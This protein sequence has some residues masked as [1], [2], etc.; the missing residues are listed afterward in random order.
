MACVSA[1]AQWWDFTDPVALPGTVNS[2]NA[3]ESMPVFSADSATLYFVR[4][5]DTEN[6]G[7]VNDQDIWQSSRQEDG[8]YSDLK[9]IKSLNNKF[10]NGVVGSSRDG[11]TLYLLH[12]YDGKKDEEKGIAQSVKKNGNWSTPE[13]ITIPGLDIN[14]AYY[15]FH[16]SPKGDIIIISYDGPNSLGEEDLYVSEKVGG[17]WSAP[18]HMGAVIN[19][20]GF[21]ISPYLSPTQDTLF[22]STNGM[23]GEGDADIFY[24][25]K[26]G[27][28]TK[29]SSPKNL[30]NRINS[31]KFDA[32]FSY[33]GK[34]AYWSSNRD[35]ELGDIYKIEILTPPPLEISCIGT[36]VSV[37]GGSDGMVDL[38]INGGGAPY[39]FRWSNGDRT[40]DVTGLTAGDYTVT[41]T[42]VI[43]Q[44]ATTTCSLDEPEKRIDPVVISNYE[45]HEFKHTFKYNKNKLSVNKGS[46]RKFVRT[47]KKDFKEGRPEITINVYSSASQVPTQTYGSNA[48][49]AKIRA[50]N[51]KYDLVSH[52]KK[53][54]ADKVN[55]VIVE[56]KVA[57]P[58]YEED[59]SNKRKYEPYQYVRLSTE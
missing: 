16:V 49:L 27:S 44:V 56:T 58:A 20:G 37:Y 36:N 3:D 48:N 41:V 2:V 4:T 31:P 25:V 30:G 40:E 54:H 59:A 7:G 9:R 38:L 23:G 13:E 45:N 50:E 57:G 14:G 52:F 28:W 21:E 34:S 29:W 22:F 6:Q 19:S 33:T 8:S 15:G 42:D 10:N 24:A 51:M 17:V 1:N 43:G 32:Y 5:G 11:A 47:V 46:L 26:Q 39:A 12:T 55:V 18:R 53:K 35:G